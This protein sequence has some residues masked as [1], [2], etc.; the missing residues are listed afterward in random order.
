LPEREEDD[1]LD[2]EELEDRVEGAQK[3]VGREVEQKQGVQ[4]Q[5]DAAVVDE[6]GVEVALGGRPVPVVVQVKCLEDDDNEGHERLDYAEL[7]GALLAEPKKSNVVRLSRYPTC[8]VPAARPDL[9]S[10]YLWHNAAFS[11]EIL[12][13]QTEEVV[14]HKSLVAIPDSVEVDVVVVVA[15][16]EKAEPGGQ[17]VYRHNEQDPYDP[18]LFRRV[19]VVS[20]ILEDLVS[21]E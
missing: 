16:E 12:V 2:G 5:G 14:D 15:E 17:R 19:G 8:S 6:G 11:S 9:L 20:E 7:Q 21:R 3:V 4:G 18:S 10:S 1:R 13:A